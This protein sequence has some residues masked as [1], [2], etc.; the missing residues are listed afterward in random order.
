M[1]KCVRCAPLAAV[2]AA[3]P[4]A[5][6]TGIEKPPSV[7]PEVE[8]ARQACPTV[9]G[10]CYGYHPTRWRAL[11]CCTPESLPPAALPPAGTAPIAS[12]GRRVTSSTEKAATV[13]RGPSPRTIPPTAVRPVR[14][15]VAGDDK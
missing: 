1:W 3:A 14:A 6:A 10:P 15:W 5:L 12:Y 4:P 2:L 9:V 7:P 8:E 13:D 11:P